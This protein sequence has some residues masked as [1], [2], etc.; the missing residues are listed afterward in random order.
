[1]QIIHEQVQVRRNNRPFIQIRPYMRIVSR[2]SEV[3]ASEAEAVPPFNPFKLYATEAEA[4]D[5]DGSSSER[6]SDISVRVVEL[7]GGILPN[8]DGQELD[9]AEV[10]ELVARAKEEAK[11]LAMRPS[12]Q[13]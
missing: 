1:K 3:P 5:S 6:R 8:E 11:N 7:L 2:L 9:E 4:D 10:A 13:P 12:L